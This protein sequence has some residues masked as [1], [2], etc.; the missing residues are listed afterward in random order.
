M[1]LNFNDRLRGTVIKWSFFNSF[2]FLALN[3]TCI[4]FL[5]SAT[6]IIVFESA[7]VNNFIGDYLR[8]KYHVF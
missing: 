7:C 6:P 4:S 2:L 5:F 8:N 3:S 1:L